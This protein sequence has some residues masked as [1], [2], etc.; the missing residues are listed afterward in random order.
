MRNGRLAEGAIVEDHIERLSTIR[1]VRS[2][3]A[4]GATL[5]GRNVIAVG[6]WEQL[7]CMMPPQK[8]AGILRFSGV[9]SRDDLAGYMKDH[10]TIYYLPL[11][12]DYVFRVN[13][14]DLARYGAKDLRTVYERR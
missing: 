6:S 2:L 3:I 10:F 1:N 12:R 9:M 14:I 8:T 5:P 11:I 7:T 4:L 13:G